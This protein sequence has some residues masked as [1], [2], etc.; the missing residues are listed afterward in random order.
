MTLSVALGGEETGRVVNH[1][2][3]NGGGKETK[4]KTP[5]LGQ[6]Q[7]IIFLLFPFIFSKGNPQNRRVQ[8]LIGNRVNRTKSNKACVSLYSKLE[9]RRTKPYMQLVKESMLKGER[10]EKGEMR[11]EGEK[12]KKR[13]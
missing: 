12:K 2:S 13:K 3:C 11:K 9:A 4:E 7:I 5:R 1:N 8:D 10:K 6:S